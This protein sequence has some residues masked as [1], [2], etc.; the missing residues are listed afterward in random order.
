[1]PFALDS[2]PAI[3]EISEAIN[4]LLGNFGANISADPNTGEVKGPT[5]D[6]LGYLYKYLSV[7]YADSAD[8]ALNFGNTPT[9]R[10]YYGLRNSDNSVESLNPAD[11]IWKEVDGGFSTTKFLF[12]QTTGGR[13][14]DIIIDTTNP[15]ENYVQD[16]GTAID[17]DSLTAG[18]GR[19]VAYPTIYKW[20]SI[21]TPPA[22]PSITTVFTWET[23]EYPAPPGW[24]VNPP[25]ST[26]TDK[27][28]WGITVPL[29]AS[30]NDLTSIC[31][32]TNIDYA[33]YK[34]AEN[35]TNGL[36]FI[37]AY[38][39]QNQ[40]LPEPSFTATTVGATIPVGWSATPPAVSV[41]QVLWYIQGQFNSSDVVIDGVPSNTTAWT[42]PIA[43][44]VFQDIRSDN[45]NGSNPPS[46]ATPST[47]GTAGYY[48]SR[49]T[50]TAIL[51][52]L[53]ARGTLQ[54]GSSPAVSGTTMTG[55]GGVIN[56]SGTFALGNSTTNISYNGSQMTLN[57]NVVSTQNINP[58]GV[59][60]VASFSGYNGNNV[61]KNAGFLSSYLGN[62]NANTN[63]PFLQSSVGTAGTHYYV[64]VAGNTV[65]D[66]VG[67]WVLT[68]QAYFDGLV[69]SHLWQA[70]VD[71]PIFF[72]QD[73]QDVLVQ[74]SVNLLGLPGPTG[75]T[76]S[77]IKVTEL[78]TGLVSLDNGIS[79]TDSTC[80]TLLYDFSDVPQGNRIFRLWINQSVAGRNYIFA[81]V[82]FSVSGL[83][84]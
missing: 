37:N 69:W 49:T 52:N 7:K 50:G 36:S 9:N 77:Y 29:S 41:G 54:S 31:D 57:G 35:G 13:Q 43:A 25:N 75:A 20:T 23:G 79:H 51:N 12:Y 76:S 4:Y 17:L 33:I 32:W 66:G 61:V 11:Y 56:S 6:V 83:K 82:S 8:G 39:S 68:D 19:Q 42:G 67:N 74:A 47:W 65:L 15:T 2:S 26:S 34:I 84:R 58:F 53:G 16:D 18:R 72:A 5:G 71:V 21:N 81:N 62:W 44:S 14:I 60:V 28:L 27:Y 46:F 73:T 70:V 24:G 48:I 10:Q 30:L 1:M 80:L 64:S 55:A 78:T 45:W 22:R 3:S 40:S 59:T 63:T 38:L